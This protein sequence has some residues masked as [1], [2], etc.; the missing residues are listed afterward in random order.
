[1]QYP[2]I[3]P[4][5]INIYGPISLRWYSLAYIVGFIFCSFF[6]KKELK[7]KLKPD[8]IESLVNHTIIGIIVGARIGYILFYDPV[9]YFNNLTAILKIWEGGLAFHGG[10]IGLL[11]GILLFVKSFNKKIQDTQSK[12][13]FEKNKISFFEIGDVISFSVPFGIIFGRMANFINGELYGRATNSLFGMVFPLDQMQ[14]SRHPVQLYESL[15]EGII[16]LIIM[17]TLRYKKNLQKKPGYLSF[18]FIV[19][20]NSFRFF[21]EFF[22]EADEG[23]GY[24]LTYFTM[25]HVL[26]LTTIILTVIVFRF[27]LHKKP[28]KL[29]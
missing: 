16:L 4:E 8:N 17:L 13:E 11:F 20:Y 7:P 10:F 28:K 24:F 2:N 18:S 6:L 12:E 3:N 19:L 14:I 21:L 27:L 15:F 22:K 23:T 5:I 9:Y 25:G 29:L 26:C 1:M